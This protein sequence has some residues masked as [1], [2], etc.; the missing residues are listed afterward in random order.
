[1]SLLNFVWDT[2]WDTDI[3]IKHLGHDFQHVGSFQDTPLKSV[4]KH[5]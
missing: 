1:M 3:C 2:I 4:I 5:V